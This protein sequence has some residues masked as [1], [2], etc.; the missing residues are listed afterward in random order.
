MRQLGKRKPQVAFTCLLIAGVLIVSW[1]LFSNPPQS[2]ECKE[3]IKEFEQAEVEFYRVHGPDTRLVNEAPY[4]T[5]ECMRA[6]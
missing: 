6:T 2:A 3:R 1:V 5:I 4:E